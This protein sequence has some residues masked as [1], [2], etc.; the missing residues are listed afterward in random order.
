[1]RFKKRENTAKK[2]EKGGVRDKSGNEKVGGQLTKGPL[3]VAPW[4][5][6]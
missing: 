1:M 6:A 4:V 2:K 3:A 5:R